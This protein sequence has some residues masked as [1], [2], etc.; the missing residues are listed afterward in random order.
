MLKRATNLNP[1]LAM[2]VG[3]LVTILV[4][5][6]SITTSVL[7]PL[8][9]VG[10]L[11]LEQMFPLT[12]GANVGTTAT[13]L[14]ASLVSTKPESVQIA[15]CHLFFNLIGTL[16]W[17]P[18]PFMRRIPL[19]AARGLGALTRRSSSVPIV[20][21][22]VAFV[23]AP[24][25]LLGLSSLFEMGQEA[26]AYRVLGIMITVGLFAVLFRTLFWWIKQ[27][28]KKKTFDKLEAMEK[29]KQVNK[30]LPDTLDEIKYNQQLLFAR[31]EQVKESGNIVKWD[32]A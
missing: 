18:I 17:F 5:S 12:L 29:N 7:T 20:Y 9:G 22:L 6:S 26:V 1:Y 30:T 15:L 16:I 21:L 13:A 27:D 4:Q 10:V 25:G 31:L 28:G 11:P 32:K 14:L 23:L 8:V 2:V 3:M 24:M 19:G